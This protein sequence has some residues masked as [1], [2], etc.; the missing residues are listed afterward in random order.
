MY[1]TTQ[2]V[3]PNIVHSIF[4]P[5]YIPESHP[6]QAQLSLLPADREFYFGEILNALRSAIGIHRA[7]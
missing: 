7:R 4:G 3:Y 6:D 1:Q 5:G 2:S